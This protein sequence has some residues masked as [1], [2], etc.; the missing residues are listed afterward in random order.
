[1]NMNDTVSVSVNHLFVDIG[2]G[3]KWQQLLSGTSLAEMSRAA[4]C[5]SLALLANY[6]CLIASDRSHLNSS[7]TLCLLP[8]VLL[9]LSVR[10]FR[11]PFFS[12]RMFLIVRAELNLL[13]NPVGAFEVSREGKE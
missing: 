1:M 3:R 4:G 5:N 9:Y 8:G 11:S 2:F 12:S 6:R 10:I 13:C 7:Q